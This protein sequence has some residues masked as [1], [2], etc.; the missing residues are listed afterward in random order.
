M[1]KALFT[2]TIRALENSKTN[3]L[4]V[5]EITTLDGSTYN[6]P[7]S[8]QAVANHTEILK[9]N[10]FTTV[11]N[12]INK[13]GQQRRVWISLN[14]ELI[15]A[16]FDEVGNVQFA[17]VYLEE[18]ENGS[19]KL[20][21]KSGDTE[22]PLVKMLEKLLEKN[23][24][25]PIAEK[26][27]GKIAREFTIDNFTGKSANAEQWM[28]SFEKECE[29]FGVTEE[30][31]R[32]E[33]LKSFMEK[34]AADWY[35]SALLKLTVNKGWEAWKKSFVDTFGSNNWSTTRYALTFKYQSGSILDYA[36]KKEK[37][38]LELRKSMD[39]ETIID[40][41]AVG[42]PNFILDKIDRKNLRKT[43][44]LFGEI[45][46]DPGS[47]VSLINSKLV[48][49]KTSNNNFKQK[50]RLRTIGGVNR[51]KGLIK[52]KAK[53]FEIE[54][55]MNVFIVD[56]K[57]FEDDFL[58]GLDYIGKFRLTL[59]EK[60]EVQQRS[61]DTAKELRE[62]QVNFNEH[63]D[64]NNFEAS[65]NHL[66]NYERKVIENII[67]K[68]K[69]IFAKDRYDVGTV[70]EYEARI[71]LIV[72][73]Y[74]SKRPYRCTVEDRK[75]IEM[76]VAELLKR[77]LIEESYS[78]F[79][80]PVTLAYKKEEKRRSRLCIDFRDLNKIIVPQ[81][82]P[83]PLI[84]DMVIKTRDCKYFTKLDINSAFWSIPLR[85]E[86]RE[87][88]GF[89]TQEGHF[90][91]TC[92]PF[93]MKTSPAIFQRILS[94]I[95]R[96]YK[97]S[98][99]AVNYID[100]ILIFSKT[101]EEHI[102]HISA[103]LE[104]IKKEGFRLKLSKCT[105]ALDSVQYLGHIIKYN[106]V[107]P[108][109]DNLVSIRNFPIPRNQ[110]N[111]RQ[112][113]GKINFYNAYVP[114]ISLILEPLHN[115][116][117]KGQQFVWTEECQKTFE[118]MKEFL[119][120]QPVLAIYD[121]SLPIHIYTDASLQG[122][123]AVFKQPQLNEKL[124]EEKPVAYFSR[125]L[126]EA[127]KRKKAI[128][129]EC[130]AIKEAVKYWQHWLMGRPFKIFSDHK[131]LE[132]MNVKA[133][134]DEELG[135]LAYYLSQYDFEIIYHPGKDNVE[136]DCLS[137]NPVLEPVLGGR[138]EEKTLRV[139]NVIKIE[140][141]I[142]DQKNNAELQED[143][144]KL[145]LRDEIYYKRCRNKEKIWLSEKCC[146]ELIEKTHREFCH[147]GINQ[148]QSKIIPYY[149]AKNIRENIK[150][151]CKGCEICIR[152][153]SRGQNKIGLLSQFGPAK[154]PFEI[155]SIDTIGGLGGNRSSKK[156]LHLLV[157]HF[158]RFA[159]IL[160]SKTQNSKDFIKL[161]EKV[162]E[163]HSVKMVLTDQYPGINS[164]EFKDFLKQKNILMVFT[165]INAPFSNG[166]NE[167]LNQT[168]I[169]KI[170]CAVNEN[171]NRSAWT[172][173]AQKCVE[174][175]NET[176]HTVTG[177]SPKFLLQGENT[178]SLPEKLREVTDQ[179]HLREARATA[180]K[181]S[182]KYHEYNKKVYDKNRKDQEF[183]VGDMVY[184]ENG[185]RL[186]RKKLDELRIGPYKIKKKVS[187]SMYEVDIGH[188]KLESCLYHISKLVPAFTLVGGEM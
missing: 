157:D 3:V 92:L 175:Y 125:K 160:T 93:G 123:G 153:K 12:S 120:T 20:Q 182:M 64:Q 14:K 165:A 163:D 181:N 152:N 170:R 149:T 39:V 141:I 63:V 36:L 90:H 13:R 11:K 145:K 73:K 97:L 45:I 1:E 147:L 169:N 119:C 83:F 104:A 138:E 136:A 130:L 28:K 85:I 22:Q 124:K 128:Y 142:N 166:L 5:S 161:M 31:N 132:K 171:N 116:L 82:Q 75:E 43:E 50:V 113:L 131:P 127:Q 48:R 106:S 24:E 71:D 164:R 21:D 184:V 103:L 25:R 69:M 173:L 109:N 126:N 56:S 53:I 94:N 162:L 4:C 101:F 34:E 117:R 76:Q 154:E 72:D 42:L 57:Y 137:R 37:L 41:I 100:D 55:S 15:N 146:K 134:T 167:R 110:K 59:N 52:V 6:F 44:D 143:R 47:N 9:T 180:L 122:I 179:N 35:A 78:P 150:K 96:K 27:M 38:L 158:T 23:Q 70:K 29:R 68:Y 105:F 80:A 187:N 129:L 10:A 98:E 114:R 108:L 133:R 148:M 87:K 139:V 89:V 81:A 65:M 62:Y 159:C 177:F 17:G 18:A 77:N 176:D 144:D 84:E 111:V 115:L 33:I 58:I 66:N 67:D 107:S 88:T 121:P 174:K 46:Y 8:H 186:N 188:K 91:W 40:L 51:S 151:T 54:E 135:D 7:L 60:L 102:Q 74:C 172:K 112:F 185:N 2:F 118:Y 168:L 79:A 61:Y 140:E 26:N 156:Y 178:S 49:L 32:I 30:E 95:I 99:C 86:D 183:K 19:Q 16:Y 155:V